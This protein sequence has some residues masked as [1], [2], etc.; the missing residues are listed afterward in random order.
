MDFSKSLEDEDEEILALNNLVAEGISMF[1]WN[2]VYIDITFSSFEFYEE[3][4]EDYKAYTHRPI[5]QLE[6]EGEGMTA[7]NY[8][9]CRWHS[10]IKDCKKGGCIETDWGCG[11]LLLQPCTGKFFRF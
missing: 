7:P 8:C 1:Q 2:D 10:L 9:T 4:K 3:G 6:E 5:L 11:W